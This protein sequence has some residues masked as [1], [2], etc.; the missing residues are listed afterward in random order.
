MNEKDGRFRVTW[1]FFFQKILAPFF[2]TRVLL[3][4]A[5][6]L[7]LTQLKITHER[8]VWEIGPNGQSRTV[9]MIPPR[10]QLSAGRYWMV[11]VFSRWDAEWYLG[12]VKRGYHYEPGP[13][14]HSNTAFFPLYPV[15]MSVVAAP[16]GHS[17]ASILIAG[18]LISNVALLAALACLVD[19]IGRDF[20][21]DVAARSVF[22]LLIFPSTFFFSAVYTESLFLASVVLAFQCA[23]SQRWWLAGLAG[24]AATLTRPP[25]VLIG[26]ALA[27]EYLYQRQFR[28]REIRADVLALALMPLALIAHFSY[29]GWRF[30]NFWIFIQT[31]R[32]WGRPLVGT[33]AGGSTLGHFSGSD[34]FLTILTV[35]LFAV[36]WRRLRPSYLLYS[37]LAFLMPLASGKLLGMGRF[38]AI[39]FPL[40]IL[41][42]LV[43]KNPVLD[44]YWLII[45]SAS[46][47]LFMALFCQWRY[48]G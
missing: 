19:L 42:G 15:L 28:W 21:E 46:A 1:R 33:P 3:L 24:A 7:A 37:A 32:D 26:A 12:M 9:R 48:V 39:I 10:Q 2:V 43:G 44:R 29:L 25:G 35:G 23:R 13:G 47:V 16:L 4:V 30:G 6:F 27:L 36:G 22:Y 20:D 18:M 40:Y 31:E 38:C 34:L 8:K 17:D 11:N 41:L 45:S 14:P 5:G